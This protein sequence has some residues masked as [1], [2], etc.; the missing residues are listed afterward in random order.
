MTPVG[1]V[2]AARHRGWTLVATCTRDA[3][4]SLTFLDLRSVLEGLAD[5]AG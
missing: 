4:P 5:A 3:L 2:F 1:A